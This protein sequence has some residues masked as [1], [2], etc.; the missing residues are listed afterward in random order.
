VVQSVQVRLNCTDSSDELYD[1]FELTRA[2]VVN[3][4]TWNQ[5]AAGQPWAV[6]GAQGGIDHGSALLGQTNCSPRGLNTIALHGNAAATVRGASRGL[7]PAAA[8]EPW[9]SPL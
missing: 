3:E 6:P 8:A 5:W 7:Q 4:A 1:F 9:A 2:W